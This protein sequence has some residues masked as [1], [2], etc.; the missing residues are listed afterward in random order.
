MT[1]GKMLLPTVWSAAHTGRPGGTD[2]VNPLNMRKGSPVRE[3]IGVKDGYV[4]V[5]VDAS[6]IEARLAAWISGATDLV[7]AF[8]A[9]VD[10]YSGVASVLFNKQVTKET[11]P[12]EREIGKMVKL[13]CQYGLGKV[14]LARRLN[15][16]GIPTTEDEAQTY[17]DI[18][19]STYTE[20]VLNGKEFIFLL[21]DCI[22]KDKSVQH[23]GCTL[24]PMG[25]ELPAGYGRALRYDQLKISRNNQLE[26]FSPRYKSWQTLH[27]GLI[28]ENLCQSLVND[29][30][31]G[32]MAK[33]ID[34]VLLMVYD[35]LM[36]LVKTDE[37]ESYL[38]RVKRDMSRPSPWMTKVMD[39]VLPPLS[40]SGAIKHH[41]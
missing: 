33:Y 3:A 32:V 10:V 39:G 13:A 29:H 24:S 20:I 14:T 35:N 1:K 41:L 6:Q 11:F 9:G 34:K 27:W 22:T 18:Y 25:I 15:A 5:D 26:Y 8:A 7:E 38:K 36:L 40:A 23:K 31:G 19:R 30:I 2:G 12:K 37:A 4:I 16:I 17:V 28:N 21:M